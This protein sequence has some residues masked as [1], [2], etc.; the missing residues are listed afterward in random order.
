LFNPQFFS[1]R[2]GWCCFD[3]FFSWFTTITI[4]F[5]LSYSFETRLCFPSMPDRFASC[6]AF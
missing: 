2:F 4:F 3:P 5:L 6:G 1:F